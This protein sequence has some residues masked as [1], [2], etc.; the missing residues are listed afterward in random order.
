MK[1]GGPATQNGKAVVKWNATRH[2]ISSPAPV[3]PGLERREDWQKH[4]DGILVNP[5]PVG[6]L[7]VTLAERVALLSWR[8]HRVTRF[9][10]ETVAISQGKVEGDI[11]R[12][13]RFLR[14]IEENPYESTHPEDIRFEAKYN[15]QIHNALKRLPSL[16]PGKVLKGEVA[17]S[18]V[19]AV[20]MAAQRAIGEEIDVERLD[21]PGVPE[22]AYLRSATGY[23]GG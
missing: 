12:R 14:S 22:D 2:G 21:L 13:A 5:S 19:Q 3:I 7:E 11:Q 18:I 23:E 8:L 10:T 6:H 1:R 4:K 17:S 16:E 20:L 9:E 15:R